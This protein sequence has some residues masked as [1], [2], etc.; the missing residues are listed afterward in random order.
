[1]VRQ[2]DLQV[3]DIAM[4][5]IVSFMLRER[6]RKKG[7]N[8]LDIGPNYYAGRLLSEGYHTYFRNMTEDVQHWWYKVDPSL[9]MTTVQRATTML[10]T[11]AMTG[12][13]EWPRSTRCV[14]F[15]M[16]RAFDAAQQIER[17]KSSTSP[18]KDEDESGDDDDDGGNA[19]QLFARLLER[20]RF[21]T[22]Q[23]HEVRNASSVWTEVFSAE[24]RRG[25]EQ[26]EWIDLEIYRYAVQRFIATA[27]KAGCGPEL[28]RDVDDM[29][30]GT[31]SG[32]GDFDGLLSDAVK[33]F[34]S[35]EGKLKGYGVA[36]ASSS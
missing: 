21:N 34:R 18:L 30:R 4:D 31:G 24:Q 2:S 13:Y 9:A 16:L 14:S 7:N 8:K 23:Y 15:S 20:R 25:F 35:G 36:F 5:N 19:A 12:I 26:H 10:D 3:H 22:G 1:M 11:F 28:E 17:S 29:E 27:Y 6:G 32:D 33:Q